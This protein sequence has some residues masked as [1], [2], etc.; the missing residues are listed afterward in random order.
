MLHNL[1]NRWSLLERRVALDDVEAITAYCADM[2]KYLNGRELTQRR[3]LIESFV[4]EIVVQPGGAV[5]RLSIPMSDDSPTWR[6]EP[7]E[8]A[9]PVRWVVNN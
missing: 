3:A 4:R 9:S 7:E 2:S 5:V 6:R 8:G 1:V